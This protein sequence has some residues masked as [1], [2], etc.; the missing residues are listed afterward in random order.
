MHPAVAPVGGCDPGGV[1]S[2]KS[3]VRVGSTAL[4]CGLLLICAEFLLGF[5]GRSRA[6]DQ[7]GQHLLIW[8]GR[9]SPVLHDNHDQG[10][11]GG[12]CMSHLPGTCWDGA[13]FP[14]R[15]KLV[16]KE[17]DGRVWDGS[18]NFVCCHVLWALA[19]SCGC[20]VACPVSRGPLGRCSC[21]GLICAGWSP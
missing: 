8:K 10:E 7:G 17:L 9:K 20:S 21:L 15:W 3:C 19:P 18:A 6:S 13:T 12:T 2:K 14:V 16:A 5:P 1:F 4:P 11:H